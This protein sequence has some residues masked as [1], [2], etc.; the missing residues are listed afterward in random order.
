[1]KYFLYAVCLLLLF[2][3]TG[4]CE[5][6]RAKI[7]NRSKYNKVWGD[8]EVYRYKR[9][10]DIKVDP[11][12]TKQI[13]IGA[14]TPNKN[15]RFVENNLIIDKINILTSD[16]RVKKDDNVVDIMPVKPNNRIKK[17][18]TYI[19]TVRVRRE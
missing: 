19:G 15:Q 6:S 18:N 10:I 12:T 3:N 1:M 13:N 17:F 16:S 7:I 11:K 4:F 8:G 2:S 9:K 14:V 5:D